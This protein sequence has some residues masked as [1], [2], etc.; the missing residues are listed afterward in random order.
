[1]LPWQ[2]TTIP[3][4]QCAELFCLNAISS[5]FTLI[6]SIIEKQMQFLLTLSVVCR[7]SIEMQSSYFFG[8]IGAERLF[9]R[10]IW[11]WS[12]SW[13]ELRMCCFLKVSNCEKQSHNN[14]ASSESQNQ[15]QWSRMLGSSSNYTKVEPI[16]SSVKSKN[17][18]QEWQILTSNFLWSKALNFE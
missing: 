12:E 13:R 9:V 11:L 3:Q 17:N 4:L 10:I 2:Q 14:V 15:I 16:A 8:S 5:V 1:M 18:T 7:T 6:T